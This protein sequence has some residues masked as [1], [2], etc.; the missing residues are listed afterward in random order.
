M[1]NILPEIGI[2]SLAACLSLFRFFT[3]NTKL[4][5]M[6]VWAT[7]DLATAKKLAPT[8]LNL[9]LDIITVLRVQ[10]L[11]NSAK[12]AFAFRLLHIY[13]VL[14]SGE[15]YKYKGGVLHEKSN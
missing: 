7:K 1:K 6:A 11:T 4:A 8:E 13:A 2:V 5:E 3:V 12:L 14:I 15:S 9:M 10:C